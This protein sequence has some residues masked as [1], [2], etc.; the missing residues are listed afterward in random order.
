MSK[1]DH[2]KGTRE[3]KRKIS[4]RAVL[5]VGTSIAVTS[6]FGGS[7]AQSPAGTVQSAE[8]AAPPD[9][10]TIEAAYIYL[11]SRALVLRQ[12]NIDRGA[13]G[14]AYNMIKYNPIGEADW[15]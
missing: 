9:V 5:I 1:H 3:E 11:L 7:C 4:R 8:H 6:G 2:R 15:V 12:E 14:F 10:A 13:A